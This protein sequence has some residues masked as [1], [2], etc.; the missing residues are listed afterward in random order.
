V[1]EGGG[2]SVR[3]GGSSEVISRK[4]SQKRGA[5]EFWVRE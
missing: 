4:A 3:G 2:E 1:G 5:S